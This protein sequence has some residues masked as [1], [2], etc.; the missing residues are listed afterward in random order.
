[1]AP[2]V[3]TYEIRDLLAN[4]LLARV[5]LVGTRYGKVLNDTSAFEGTLPLP[6]FDHL[7]NRREAFE[8]TTPAHTCVYVYR[9]N[10]VVWGGIIWTSNYD[11]ASNEIKLGAADWWSY[12]DHRKILPVLSGAA[13]TDTSHIAGLS[14]SYTAQ[15]S[16]IA[17]NL[18]ALAQS[19]TNGDIGVVA[20]TLDYGDP[21]TRTYPGYATTPVGDQWRNLAGNLD[22]PDIRFDTGQPGTDGKPVRQMLIGVPELGVDGHQWE[23][24]KNIDAYQWP[25]DGTKMRT[26]S[27]AVGEGSDLGTPIGAYEDTGLYT[28]GWP[29]LEEDA[30]YDRTTGS[31]RLLDA[32]AADQLLNRL[33]VVLPTLSVAGDAHPTVTELAPGDR[34]RVKIRDD[35]H[36]YNPGLDTLARLI[37]LEVTPD[38]D[39]GEDVTLTLAPLIE[40]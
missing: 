22:G 3:Y 31:D 2:S 16:V 18:L 32:A 35:Y 37:Q 33:P 15:Y 23:W 26:R 39:N 4:T 19:H 34:G 30:S 28:Y 20:S 11:S 29:L 36:G 27:F 7:G 14:V 9:D 21:H 13:F 17:R 25:R 10:T 24:G 12:F 5:P 1:M 6:L 8:L 38:G 40:G